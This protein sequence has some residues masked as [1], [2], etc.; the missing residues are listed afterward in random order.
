LAHSHHGTI[1]QS[2]GVFK[3]VAAD[4]ANVG[5]NHRANAPTHSLALKE[6]GASLFMWC[7][8]LKGEQTRYLK[9]VTTVKVRCTKCSIP[10]DATA[11][12]VDTFGPFRAQRAPS[13]YNIVLEFSRMK[14]AGH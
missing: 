13:P 6:P 8:V 7:R 3:I 14:L 11:R 12:A 1:A 4:E 9:E 2:G 5:G 10:G